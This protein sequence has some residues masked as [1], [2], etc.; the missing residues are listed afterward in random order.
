MGGTISRRRLLREAAGAAVAALGATRT[1][2]AA[3]SS[4]APQKPL[5]VLRGFLNGFNLARLRP[6]RD[7][8][9]SS[10]GPVAG[11][12]GDPGRAC[13]L[14]LEALSP[15]EPQI[16]SAGGALAGRGGEY[17]RRRSAARSGPGP[18]AAGSED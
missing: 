1:G 11:V 8:V 2:W 4:A 6:D 3:P 10:P 14:Y 9:E 18:P 16:Q 7:V 17:R 13:F 5:N 12:L 15:V